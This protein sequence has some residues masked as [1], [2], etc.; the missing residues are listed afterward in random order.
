MS[1]VAAVGCYAG[2]PAAAADNPTCSANVC[3][4][5]SPSHRLSCEIDYQRA[6]LPD[7]VYCQASP[8]APAPQSVHMDP[9]GTY[10]VCTGEQCLG[11]AGQGQATLPYG[12]SASLGPFTC[13]SDVDGMTCTV[14]SG[15][16]FTIS[17]TAVTKVRKQ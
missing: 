17:G 7:S 5:Y 4:F 11:N 1:A 6:G 3:S 13:R 16:G 9:K 14:P 15:C 10:S 8:P 2:I 12:E